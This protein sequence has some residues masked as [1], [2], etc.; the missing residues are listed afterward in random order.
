MTKTIKKTLNIYFE[1]QELLLTVRQGIGIFFLLVLKHS[2]WFM[3]VSIIS[4]LWD[5]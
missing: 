4:V 5:L 2:S 1:L 3:V